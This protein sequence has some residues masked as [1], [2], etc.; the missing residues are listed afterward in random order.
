M[1]YLEMQLTKREKCP[2][3]SG[4]EFEIKIESSFNPHYLKS[5]NFKVTDKEYGHCWNFYLC[6]NCHFVF[7]NP[8]IHKKDILAFY[9]KLTDSNYS[10]E[11]KGR[12]KNFKKILKRL[13]HIPL[14]G[15]QLLDIGAASGIFLNVAQDFGYDV[16]GIEPSVDFVKE[17]KKIYNLDLFLGSI[18]NFKSSKRFSVISLIDI[19]EHL[20][21]PLAFFKK[22]SKLLEKEGILVIVTPDINSFAAKVFKKKWWHYRTAHVNFFNLHSIKYLLKKFNIRIIK[23][24]RYVWN[25]SLFYLL[26]RILPIKER[27]KSTLQKILKNINLKVQLFDS[28]EIYAKKN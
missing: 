17:A 19:I 22:I 28:W 27:K 12:E 21:D 15:N 8:Y 3:C 20:A 2:L 11:A 26:S 7:S 16:M 25:F 18:D 6:N 14:P 4:T 23:R 13:S 10:S 9:A 5:N 24:K 1:V